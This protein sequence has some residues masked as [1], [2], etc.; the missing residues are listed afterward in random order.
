MQVVRRSCVALGQ[1]NSGAQ[2]ALA[3][4]LAAYRND[5]GA[6]IFVMT[7]YLALLSRHLADKVCA[8]DAFCSCTGEAVETAVQPPTSS[9][10]VA[11]PLHPRVGLRERATHRLLGRRPQGATVQ[12]PHV[13]HRRRGAAW[14]LDPAAQQTLRGNRPLL[15]HNGLARRRSSTQ[16]LAL[17]NRRAGG[18]FRPVRPI[19][20]KLRT[21][22]L[23]AQDALV[24]NPDETLRQSS[25]DG[26]QRAR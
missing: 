1:L 18:A 26:W 12:H 22:A 7:G 6:Q 25:A 20:D 19:P 4:I 2:P 8:S 23:V 15:H 13:V 9:P 10:L 3:E 21:E 16:R 11:E 17:P 14:E 24:L 5:G